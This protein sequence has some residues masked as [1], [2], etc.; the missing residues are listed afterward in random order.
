MS[1]VFWKP[2]DTPLSVSQ[3]PG[4][5][6]RGQFRGRGWHDHK[7]QPRGSPGFGPGRGYNQR[8]RG[9]FHQPKGDQF[10]G[11]GDH[12]GRGRGGHGQRNNDPEL[13]KPWLN[14]YLRQEIFTKR[15]LKAKAAQTKQHADIEAFKAQEVKVDGFVKFARE[16]YFRNNPGSEAAWLTVL[17]QE[18]IQQNFVCE[19]CDLFFGTKTE[20][21]Q[22][23]AEHTTC[24]LD[25]CQFTAHPKVLEIHILHLHAS[26]LYKRI[27]HG[28]SKEAIEKWREGRKK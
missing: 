7:D 22:H 17:A 8:G 12:R 24:G 4:L 6:M 23:E 15:R 16:A 28:Y 5:K 9:S 21:N 26:G 1:N 3:G 11:R 13:N 25:G 20:L 10:R 14:Y 19:V 2:S 18:S 27:E